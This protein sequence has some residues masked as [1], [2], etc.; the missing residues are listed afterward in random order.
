MMRLMT[1]MIASESFL[2]IVL[3]KPVRPS[4]LMDS[5]AEALVDHAPKS[6]R[7]VEKSLK[8]SEP[9][10]VEEE[11]EVGYSQQTATIV[12]RSWWPKTMWST[13]W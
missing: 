7:R 9:E 12:S 10:T 6:L 5:L 11:P 4:Q 13:R 2:G 8:V 1:M 3:S